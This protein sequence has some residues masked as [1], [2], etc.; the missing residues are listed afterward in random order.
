[1]LGD[2][3][4]SMCASFLFGLDG[5]GLE[6]ETAALAESVEDDCLQLKI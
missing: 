3:A 5:A 6:E 4:S 1:M 2:L